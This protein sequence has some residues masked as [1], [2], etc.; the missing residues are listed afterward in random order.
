MAF[1]LPLIAGSIG[2]LSGFVVGYYIN[3]P[4]EPIT[5]ITIPE[6]TEKQITTLKDLTP[7]KEM[8]HELITFDKSQLKSVA[9]VATRPTREHDIM[10]TL[11]QKIA[12]R[13]ASIQ[14]V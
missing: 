11:R 7:H 12:R 14:P 13:R 8:N 10:E 1:V 9:L 2:S 5:I 6:I 4:L 3:Q